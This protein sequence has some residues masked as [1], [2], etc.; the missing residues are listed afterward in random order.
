MDSKTCSKCKKQKEFIE[1]GVN[2]SARDGF[3]HHC[4]A[5]RNEHARVW[6]ANN[7]EKV[8]ETNRNYWDKN[9]EKKVKAQRKWLQE[10]RE[11]QRKYRE[12]N[13]ERRK[14]YSKEYGEKNRNKINARAISAYRNDPQVRLAANLRNRLRSALKGVNKSASTL[15]LL[16]CN[17]EELKNHIEDQFTEGMNWDN[18]M[19]GKIHIDHIR[20]CAS[21][22]LT[23]PEQQRA[24]FN[25]TNLQPLWAEDNLRKSDCYANG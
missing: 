12:V 5:C 20:P 4:K 11:Y 8:A 23:D 10:N 18:V 7:K 24:C 19:N 25:Y 16:G 21:F 13:K 17:T 9:R 2:R 1:F 15:E 3:Q 6:R 22:D 14:N